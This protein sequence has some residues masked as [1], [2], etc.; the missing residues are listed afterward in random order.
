MT[1]SLHFLFIYVCL[2]TC[3]STYSEKYYAVWVKK[4][5]FNL[6]TSQKLTVFKIRKCVWYISLT[7]SGGFLGWGC[8]RK[9]M[10]E[11]YQW[12]KWKNKATIRKNKTKMSREISSQ[13]RQEEWGTELGTSRSWAGPGAWAQDEEDPG[14]HHSCSSACT[15]PQKLLSI[16]PTFLNSSPPLLL[17]DLCQDFSEFS[18]ST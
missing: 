18:K 10:T 16:N 14:T 3:L 1:V 4:M 6:R 9:D 8:I 2:C 7:S 15:A 5:Q 13:G 11:D 17:S 12:I